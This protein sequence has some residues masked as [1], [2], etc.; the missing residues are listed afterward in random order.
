MLTHEVV[1]WSIRSRK[2][3]RKVQ[4]KRR[5]SSSKP[6]ELRWK[7]GSQAKSKAFMTR[8]LA[9]AFR[10]DLLHAARRAEQF[11]TVT[12]LPVSMLEGD[13][14][15]STWYEFAS[16]YVAMR[17]PGAAAKTRDSIVD[18]LATAT[19]A[20][21]DGEV[22]DLDSEVVR[23]AMRWS[24]VQRRGVD[25]PPCLADA[26]RLLPK[27]TRPIY[28]LADPRVTRGVAEII[29][30]KLDGTPAAPDTVSRRW[31]ALNTAIEYAVEVGA[32]D[33]NPL[34]R[35]RRKRIANESVAVDRRVVVNQRQA[36]ELLSAVSYVGSW[37]RGRG[38]R[39]VAFFSTLYFAGLR[40]AEAVGL[41]LADCRLPESGWGSLTLG[42]T[43]P[44]SGKQWT[45]SGEVHD[46]RGLKQRADRTTREVPIPPE[47]VAA[48]R[49]HVAEFGTADDGRLFFNERRGV[50]GSSTYSRVWEE[51]RALA[52]TPPQVACPLAGR[53]YDLRHAA[54]STW[55]NAGVDP[56]DV[57][58][59]AGNS[60]EVLLKRYAKCVDGRQER[61]NN[62]IEQAL[63]QDDAR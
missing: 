15:A 11:D 22:A 24:L 55:L 20:L 36:R 60:V 17:W 28:D 6:Y 31:R 29:G 39:L 16:R 53:P 4:E 5:K 9:D 38:R 62:L 1:I 19:L 21:L 59:R 40:P 7:V 34:K 30:R 57:A 35:V 56:T 54:L 14:A 49:A 61:N 46:R 26:A 51:A 2:D 12:G 32:L 58:E 33:A 13:K 10:A 37:N 45:D 18:S 48:L 42:E 3:R 23:A 63:S 8:A 41:R 27:G 52:L 43:R 47:L 50:L 44:T 25:V